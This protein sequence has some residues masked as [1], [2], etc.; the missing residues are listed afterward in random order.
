MPV[1]SGTRTRSSKKLTFIINADQQGKLK[2]HPKTRREAVSVE[3]SCGD[4]YFF[5]TEAIDAMVAFLGAGKK[6]EQVVWRLKNLTPMYVGSV[7]DY[8][9]NKDTDER[10]F[11][12][13]YVRDGRLRVESFDVTLDWA[14]FRS[15][16][17]ELTE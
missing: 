7:G 5:K 1:A 2:F 8:V 17:K 10:T 13:I 14:S 11:S 6:P 3:W 15:A 4:R 9:V 12:D 16:W